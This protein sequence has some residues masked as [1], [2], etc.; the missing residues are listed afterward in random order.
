MPLESSTINVI[1]ET[2][3]KNIVSLRIDDLHSDN[4]DGASEVDTQA[5]LFEEEQPVDM[6]TIDA[7]AADRDQRDPGNLES[8]SEF[9]QRTGEFFNVPDAFLNF[10]IILCTL[11]ISTAVRVPREF[12]IAAYN[13]AVHKSFH[14]G[15]L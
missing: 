1:P 9:S 12:D 10:R 8:D 6:A 14:K 13:P 7:E 3:S 5:D 4:D 15:Q 11:V 2:Q